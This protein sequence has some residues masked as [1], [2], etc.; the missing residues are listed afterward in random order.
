MFRISILE[1][2]MLEIEVLEITEKES[3]YSGT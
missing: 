1:I 3:K 2:E